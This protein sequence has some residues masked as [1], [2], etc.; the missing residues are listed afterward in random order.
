ML[1]VAHLFQFYH[2]GWYFINQKAAKEKAAEPPPFPL[3]PSL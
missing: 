1:I 3:R 2:R